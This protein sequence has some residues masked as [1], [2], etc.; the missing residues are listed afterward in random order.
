MVTNK[1]KF[2]NQ[3]NFFCLFSLFY[4]TIHVKSLNFTCQLC[5]FHTWS[6]SSTQVNQR[7]M[8]V[9]FDDTK[10][11]LINSFCFFSN[12][13]SN[14]S[15][16]AICRRSVWSPVRWLAR[17]HLR[18]STMYAIAISFESKASWY[19]STVP[20]ASVSSMS[21]RKSVGTGP[22]LTIVDFLTE[23]LEKGER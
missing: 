10:R 22:F 6:F 16:S 23:Y 19:G 12:I 20:S 18:S 17:L 2:K 7:S 9:K 3:G 1:K 11:Q 8:S 14:R 4:K 13:A 21:L 5:H 15:S